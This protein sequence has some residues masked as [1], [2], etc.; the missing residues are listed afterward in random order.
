MNYTIPGI[1]HVTAICDNAQQNIDLYAGLLGL[2]VA[3]QTVNFDMP[4][5][6]CHLTG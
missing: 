3:K 1:H 4:D 2:R 5:T 6:Y